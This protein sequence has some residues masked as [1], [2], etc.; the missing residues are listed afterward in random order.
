MIDQRV[1]HD[2]DTCNRFLFWK[3]RAVKLRNGFG[4]GLRLFMR[5]PLARSEGQFALPHALASRL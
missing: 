4:E 2:D 5:K 3:K 1:V